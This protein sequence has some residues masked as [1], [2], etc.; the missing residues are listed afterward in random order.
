MT[1]ATEETM[2]VSHSRVNFSDLPGPGSQ[3]PPSWVNTHS[4]ISLL[5]SF[6]DPGRKWIVARDM[7][8]TCEGKKYWTEVHIL[9]VDCKISHD[10]PP[11][12]V[13]LQIISSKAGVYL[14]TLS[15]LIHF[16]QTWNMLK[17]LTRWGLP[18]LAG[19]GNPVTTTLWMSL[20]QHIGGWDI[21]F[22]VF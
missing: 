13:I 9:V 10:P 16:G 4:L 20:R 8:I 17:S 6:F 7:E 12:N 19:L 22:G 18:F 21:C 1:I 2:T 5:S 15:R 11:W 3:K 14:A